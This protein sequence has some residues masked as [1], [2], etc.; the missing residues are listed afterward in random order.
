LASYTANLAAFLTKQ[1]LDAPVGSISDLERSGDPLGV[2][3]N[4][5]ASDYVAQKTKI[6]NVV[7]YLTNTDLTHAVSAGDVKAGITDEPL[8][9]YFVANAEQCDLYAVPKSFAKSGFG[10]AFQKN[11]PFTDFLQPV[12]LGMLEE[13]FFEEEYTSWVQTGTCSSDDSGG[14]DDTAVLTLTAMSGVFYT[15]LVTFAISL[16]ILALEF[17]WKKHKKYLVQYVPHW[18]HEAFMQDKA[19]R[20]DKEYRKSINMVDIKT[21]KTPRGTAPPSEMATQ[22]DEVPFEVKQAMEKQKQQDDN[23]L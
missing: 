17:T 9:D 13:G 23:S 6:T 11:S 18:F 22:D 5:F 15:L 14:D 12:I 3:S 20:M 16:F 4:T 7:E 8:V 21:G 2:V 1:R 10:L 19:K